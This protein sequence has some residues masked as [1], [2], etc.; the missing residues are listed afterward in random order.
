MPAV[1]FLVVGAGI[2]G[3]SAAYRLSRRA[4]VMLLERESLPGYHTTGRS[5]AFFVP[6]YGGTQVRPLTLASADFMHH[7]PGDFTEF[8]LLTHRPSLYV[9]RADQLGA[10]RAFHGELMGLDGT[11]EWLEAGDVMA[12]A[13]M[14][15]PDY[16][17]AGLWEEACHD[18]DVGTL[19]QA[20]LR[21]FKRRGGRLVTDAEVTAA[22]RQAGLWH[23][24]A[25]GE[26]FEAPVLIN[27]AGAWGD[28][29]ARLAGV[30][31]VGLAPLRRTIIT[32]D[33]PQG[34]DVTGWPL[35]LDVGHEFYFKPESGRIL[36]SP[37]DETPSPASD[38]Q[39]ETED[40]AVLV[41]RLEAA[42]MLRV[43]RLNSKWAGLRTFAPDRAPV[44][45][46]DDQ[47]EGFFWLVGQGG[48]GIQTSPAASVLA[49]A[50]AMGEALPAALT[51]AGLTA[52]SYDVAR[53]R[54]SS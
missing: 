45:G 17:A 9:A 44:I 15:A 3:A 41:H 10:L 23:V 38:V 26:T 40:I 48:F 5:A 22:R 27:A 52:T 21:G 51:E 36:A 46:F 20:F 1:D 33:G 2:A 6:S 24:T 54:A 47:A 37:S 32:F 11:V 16:A 53:L 49:A 14:L 35:V 12:R 39:P 8:D 25:G 30:A 19:H 18:I 29:L 42:T 28:E 34:R 31:P 7:P 4:R 50:L 43:P 13:P